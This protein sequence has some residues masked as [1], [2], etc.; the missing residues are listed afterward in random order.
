MQF[1]PD[2]APAM[3]KS[4]NAAETQ[5]ERNM[6]QFGLM[7][8]YPEGDLAWSQRYA[9]AFGELFVQDAFYDLVLAAH[10]AGAEERPVLLERIQDALEDAVAEHPDWIDRGEAAA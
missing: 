8:R 2:V 7:A 9:R 3:R 1:N 4:R 10:R 5:N 6:V